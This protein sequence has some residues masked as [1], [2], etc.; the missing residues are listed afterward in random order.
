M[1]NFWIKQTHNYKNINAIN[2]ETRY[3]TF[4]DKELYAVLF[5]KLL[6]F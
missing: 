3:Q 1:N 2:E 6:G 5:A 4:S